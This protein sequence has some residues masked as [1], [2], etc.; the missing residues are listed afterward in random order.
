VESKN[1]QK[2]GPTGSKL[3]VFISVF[4]L[5]LFLKKNIVI[6]HGLMM[7]VEKKSTNYHLNIRKCS[8]L[9]EKWIY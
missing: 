2:F 6:V 7:K 1:W 5:L 9:D 3:G 4:G 8:F